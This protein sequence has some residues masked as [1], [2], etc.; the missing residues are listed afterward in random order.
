MGKCPFS[1]FRF[2]SEGECSRGMSNT[3]FFD[4]DVDVTNPAAVVAVLEHA[5]NRITIWTV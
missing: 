3:C 4:G 5:V 1:K 2:M